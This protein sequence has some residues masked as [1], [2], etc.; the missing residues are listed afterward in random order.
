MFSCIS[1]CHNFFKKMFS[2]IILDFFLFSNHFDFL[3]DKIMSKKI[4]NF[5]PR[6]FSKVNNF[7]FGNFN[8]V[9]VKS[10]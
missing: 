7:S 9:N 3:N 8:F 6:G 2:E 4:F 5:F 10:F 1:C